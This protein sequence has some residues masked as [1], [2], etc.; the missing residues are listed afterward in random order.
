MTINYM[1]HEPSQNLAIGALLPIKKNDPI[2]LSKVCFTL[3]YNYNKYS[4]CN[5][6]L[7]Q[8][9]NCNDDDNIDI[10]D[11]Y[12]QNCILNKLDKVN[13]KMPQFNICVHTLLDYKRMLQI[14]TFAESQTVNFPYY[15]FATNKKI[16]VLYVS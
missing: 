8:H 5:E 2:H 4:P 9:E 13:R 16:L 15:T 14:G 6:Y 12:F 11:E 1:L 10:V 3:C 7:R